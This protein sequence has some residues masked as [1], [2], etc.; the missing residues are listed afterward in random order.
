[1]FW[2]V[3]VLVCSFVCLFFFF[4]FLVHCVTLYIS[5]LCVFVRN[6]SSC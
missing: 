5:L 4:V 3:L 2:L 6:Y 1:L